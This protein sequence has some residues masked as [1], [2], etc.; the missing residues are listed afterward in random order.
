[1]KPAAVRIEAAA[2]AGAKRVVLTLNKEVFGFA[3]QIGGHGVTHVGPNT[4]LKYGDFVLK[5]K[6]E[7]KRGKSEWGFFEFTMKDKGPKN[8][9][10]EFVPPV[11]GLVDVQKDDG[12]IQHALLCFSL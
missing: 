6:M 1:M 7:D 3:N 5:P 12:S 2:A 4:I 10:H 9:W 11:E 8:R